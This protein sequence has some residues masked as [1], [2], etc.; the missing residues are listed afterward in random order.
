MTPYTRFKDASEDNQGRGCS[1]DSSVTKAKES[2]DRRAED[3]EA[4][5]RDKQA[6]ERASYRNA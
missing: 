6:S 5:L 4:T 2:Y 3:A 1:T